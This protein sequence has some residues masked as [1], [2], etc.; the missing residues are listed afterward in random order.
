M[1][2][3]ILL[4]LHII[5]FSLM[6]GWAAGV[7]L[8]PIVTA[9]TKDPRGVE[10]M[11]RMILKEDYIFMP[12]TILVLLSGIGQIIVSKYPLFNTPWLIVH[13]VLFV[14]IVG[15]GMWMSQKYSVPLWRMAEKDIEAGQISAEAMALLRQK[16]IAFIIWFVIILVQISLPILAR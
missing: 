3:D 11:W 6:I 13:I 9:N 12:A 15:Y 14:V 5:G 7:L 1:L 2:H 16:N 8:L 10:F 4:I